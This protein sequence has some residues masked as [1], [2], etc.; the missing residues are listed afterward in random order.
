MSKLLAS[1]N[2]TIS[3][4]CFCKVKYLKPLSPLKPCRTGLIRWKVNVFWLFCSGSQV[5]YCHGW[6]SFTRDNKLARPD[7]GDLD[8]VL[9]SLE[10]DSSHGNSKPGQTSRCL[11]N[12]RWSN[13][14]LLKAVPSSA[15]QGKLVFFCL[16]SHAIRHQVFSPQIPFFL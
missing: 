1:S 12:S 4:F 2:L 6:V 14:E 13:S 15:E 5:M 9:R 7:V 3:Y 10:H 16:R 11:S 8:S